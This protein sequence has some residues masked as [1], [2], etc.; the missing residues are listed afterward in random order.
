MKITN[1][2]LEYSKKGNHKLKLHQKLNKLLL[3]LLSLFYIVLAICIQI[4][5]CGDPPKVEVNY[6]PKKQWKMSKHDMAD[7]KIDIEREL[8]AKILQ[9][10]ID[11]MNKEKVEEYMVR[12]MQYTQPQ[13]VPPSL[14]F[15]YGPNN[16][17]M[18]QQAPFSSNNMNVFP[19]MANS[20][21]SMTHR[22]FDLK[23]I[24][25]KL[26]N[27]I[28]RVSENKLNSFFKD[29][30]SEVNSLKHKLDQSH[31]VGTKLVPSFKEKEDEEGVGLGEEGKSFLEESSSKSKSVN[32]Q[33]STNFQTEKKWLNDVKGVESQLNGIINKYK[34]NIVDKEFKVFSKVF[35][36]YNSTVHDVDFS[37]INDQIASYSDLLNQASKE[38]T[39]EINASN[40]MLNSTLSNSFDPTDLTRVFKKG[41][42]LGKKMEN[43]KININTLNNSTYKNTANNENFER[44]NKEVLLPAEKIKFDKTIQDESVHLN[45]NSGNS[46]VDNNNSSLANKGKIG[47]PI[48]IEKDIIIN[49]PVLPSK[50]FKETTISYGKT[51]LEKNKINDKNEKKKNIRGSLVDVNTEEVPSFDEEHEGPVSIDWY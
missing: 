31:L 13:I 33:V 14:N 23:R 26:D 24:E 28:K 29:T 16:Y 35:K 38:E 36:K 42:S 40:K 34:S 8:R 1:S 17:N 39:N 47:F 32:T 7:L 44:E 3:T 5:F 19:S 27:V 43:F 11:W 51:L 46:P 45:N 41:N 49:K 20:R 2:L 37:K 30:I 25:G 4:S 18:N 15:P 9:M 6:L 10:Q 50:S 22:N 12:N 48:D 21:N